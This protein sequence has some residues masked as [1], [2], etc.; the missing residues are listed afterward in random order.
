MKK[1]ITILIVCVS[2]T[3]NAQQKKTYYHTLNANGTI[4]SGYVKIF[5][6]SVFDYSNDEFVCFTVEK[7]ARVFGAPFPANFGDYHLDAKGIYKNKTPRADAVG[8]A[9]VENKPAAISNL[10]GTNTG[11][12]ATNTQYSGLAASKQD[13]L[14]SGS[15]IKTINGSSVLGSGDLVVSGGAAT[16]TSGI[17]SSP[18]ASGTQTIT[19]DLGRTPSVIRIYGYGTF[20]SNAAA[21]ATTSSMGVFSS[22]GN[23]CVYQRYGAAITTTQ[24][25]L[26]SNTFAILLATGG[27]NFIS[28]VIQNVGATS[29]DIVWTETGTTTAQVFLWECQ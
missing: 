14:V 24:A 3:A 21:T 1:L 19:H 26:S 16:S 18:T 29:F 22:S 2:I 23:H 10:S 4:D 20:T 9:G 13:A 12:N 27:G 15:N 6:D 11:D 8:W 7:Y 5:T 28:G 17:G 25:G